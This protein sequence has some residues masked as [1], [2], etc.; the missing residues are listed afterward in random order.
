MRAVRVRAIVFTA[1]PIEYRTH[2]LA[3]VDYV[4]DSLIAFLG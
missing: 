3:I 4:F 1:L 2:Y